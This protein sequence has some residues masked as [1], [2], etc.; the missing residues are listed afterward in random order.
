MVY[1]QD[2]RFDKCSKELEDKMN[3]LERDAWQSFREVVHGFLGRNK[4]DNYEDLVEA[5]LQSYCK[6]GCRMSIKMHYLHSHLDFF[7]SNLTDV[8]EEHGE[9]FHQDM[10]NVFIRIFR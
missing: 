1:S 3:D 6:L 8:S 10:V 2:P 7:R 4:A 5:L 9:R